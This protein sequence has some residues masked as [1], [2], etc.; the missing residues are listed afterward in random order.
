MAALLRVIGLWRGRLAWLL[1]GVAVSLLALA[2]GISLMMFAGA[3]LASLALFAPLLLRGL[4]FVRVL[5]RYAERMVTHG[6][7]F[8]AL[9][10][11]RVWLF[12]R[13]AAN[14]AG[15]LGFRQA[16]DVLSRIVN[17]VESLD[18]VYLRILVPLAGALF[19]LPF[20]A[21]AIARAGQGWRGIALASVIGVLFVLAAFVLPWIAARSAADACSPWCKRARL[22]CLARSTLWR[23]GRRWRGRGR[24]CARRR[25]CSRCSASPSP[26]ARLALSRLSWCWP[27]S[28]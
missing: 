22:L 6:A 8:R 18:G 9:A 3:A 25:R 4:G 27:R 5:S 15:G 11:L 24:R 17:D 28:R 10:D 16:G 23:A 26:I 20:S 7:M 12:R 2:A 19:L 1:A 21:F 13:L 14:S